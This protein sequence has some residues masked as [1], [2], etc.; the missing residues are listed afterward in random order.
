MMYKVLSCCKVLIEVPCILSRSSEPLHVL[1][2]QRKAIRRFSSSPPGG[3]TVKPVFSREKPHVNVGVIG[4]LDHGK[5]SLTAAITYV[6]SHRNLADKKTCS[7]LDNSSDEKL[8]GITMKGNLLEYSTENRHYSHNDLP[9]HIG[10]VKNL[11]T[12][13]AQLDCVILVVSSEDGVTEQTKEHLIYARCRGVKS[14]V[15]YINKVDLCEE[16]I[17]DVTQME[18]M[19][20][21]DKHG[22]N[23]SKVPIIKGSALSALNGKDPGIG[24][25]SITK[26]LNALDSLLLAKHDL[27]ST[28]VIPIRRTFSITG[29]GTVASGII[30]SGIVKR[31]TEV[32]IEGYG[33]T[34]SATVTDIEIH[35]KIVDRGE[36]G[37]QIWV[38]LPGIKREDI[39]RGMV[40][41]EKGSL[42]S[43]NSVEI[44]LNLRQ[45]P[46]SLSV[47]DLSRVMLYSK[48]WNV[49]GYLKF[50]ESD[51]LVNESTVAVSL[52]KPVVMEI[53]QKLM[54]FQNSSQNFIGTA[55]VTKINKNIMPAEIEKL[56]KKKKG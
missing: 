26:L 43:F 21:I 25:N 33:K 23:S 14:L 38:L 20:L 28:L 9:G 46:D 5:T 8:K 18:V 35:N 40:L 42:S 4:H 22:F 6:L 36:A 48:T 39:S 17:V 41:A 2:L 24:S 10:Y 51:K 31:G 45:S 32:S 54:L 49:L 47:S 7:D 12:G 52:A 53:G 3:K 44:K 34:Y 11:I 13:L 50:L 27:N 19:E 56:A 15:V 30:E 29:R 1:Q 37:D 16:D 55:V